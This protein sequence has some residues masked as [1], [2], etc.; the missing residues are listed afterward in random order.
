MMQC[1]I[2]LKIKKIYNIYLFKMFDL[3]SLLFAL[4]MSNFLILFS[5]SV[6]VILRFDMYPLTRFDCYQ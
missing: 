4:S 1:V 2:V 3:G 6:N 5:V